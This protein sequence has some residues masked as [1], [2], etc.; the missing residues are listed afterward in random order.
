M[1]PVP[2]PTPP[3]AQTLERG[4]V[5]TWVYLKGSPALFR[6]RLEQRTAHFMKAD[7]LDSQFKALEEPSNAIVVDAAARPDVIVARILQ[8]I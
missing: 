6:S 5:V 7:M 4:L 1:R 3:D 2:R 8:Q